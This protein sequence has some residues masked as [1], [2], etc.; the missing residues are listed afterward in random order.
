MDGEILRDGERWLVRFERLFARPIEKVFAALTIPE[1]LAAWL[2]AA[3]IEPRPGGRFVLVFADPPYRMEGEVRDY[4]PPTL[5]AFTWPNEADAP[6]SVVR[7]ELTA[8]GSST[9]LVLTQTFI[10]QGDLPNVAAG[11]HEHL[12]RLE[13]SADGVTTTRWNRE[14]EAALAERYRAMTPNPLASPAD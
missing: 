5:F 3:V 13:L 1:R 6:P 4:Q 7:F 10:A 2:G 9:R 14:R 12:D 8:E 11:W